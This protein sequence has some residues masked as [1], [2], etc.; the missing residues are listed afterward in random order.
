MGGGRG[1]SGKERKKREKEG[2]RGIEEEKGGGRRGVG[3]DVVLMIEPYMKGRGCGCGMQ[4][5]KK[6]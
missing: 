6:T 3:M 4:K 1:G 2:K 5:K